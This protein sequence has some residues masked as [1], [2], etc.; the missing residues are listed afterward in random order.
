[1]EV[2]RRESQSLFGIKI[3]CDESFGKKILKN[4]VRCFH[5][6]ISLYKM[7]FSTKI[8]VFET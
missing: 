8:K 7:A 3:L 5:S 4:M 1:M 6:N 2:Q